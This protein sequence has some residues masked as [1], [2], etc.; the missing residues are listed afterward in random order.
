MAKM[1]VQEYRDTLR[2]VIDLDATDLPDALLDT[3]MTQG[4]RYAQRWNQGLWP[5][6]RDSW[7]YT[8]PSGSASQTLTQIED[9]DTA[10]INLIEYVRSDDRREFLFLSE[11]D[12]HRQVS[13]DS[14]TTGQPYL[15]VMSSD[16]LSV[17]LY[18]TASADTSVDFYGWRKAQDWV[19]DGAGAVSDMPE[20]FDDAIFAYA[21]GKV[22]AQQDEGQ[23]SVFWLNMADVHLVA[24]EDEFDQAAPVDRV[25]NSI[26]QAHSTWPGGRVPYDFEVG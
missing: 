14:T 13:R 18:P 1:T 7:T 19:G 10:E 11:L 24:L 25:M 15:W 22:Y 3:F 26:P 12:F 4:A 6:F 17:T 21:M 9:G 8:W 23:T 2:Q 16:R 5:F 20:Q